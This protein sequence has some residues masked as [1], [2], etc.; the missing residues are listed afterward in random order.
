V[1]RALAYLGCS[2]RITND[3]VLIREAERIIFPGVGAAG[4]SMADLK[5]LGLDALLR[6][7]LQ[8]GV[9]ILG[10]CVGLQVLLDIVRKMTPGVWASFPAKCASFPRVWPTERAAVSKSRTWAG[11]VSISPANI[12]YLQIS[13]VTANSTSFTAITL[14]PPTQNR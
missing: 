12:R 5:E 4:K 14:T 9:P 11:T 10:I 1:E 3:P 13:P 7:R 2:C 6:E 8:A